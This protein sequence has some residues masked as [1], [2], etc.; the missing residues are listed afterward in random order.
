MATSE[1]D[2]Y[3]LALSA[4]G[5]R[6]S[7]SSP[8]ENSREAEI[9]NLWFP[10]VRDFILRSAPWPSAKGYR[11]LT[12]LAE[13]DFS[14]PWVSG[15]P[16]PE[17]RFAYAVPSSMLTPRYLYGFGR[18]ALSVYTSQQG[19]TR[20]LMTDQRDAIL[21]FTRRE[22]NVALWDQQLLMA[23]VNALAAVIAMPLHGK[24]D[25][26]AAAA[27]QANSYIL[28]ARVTNANTD[29]VQYESV[30]SWIAARGYGDRA[31]DAKFVYPDG[32]M[33]SMKALGHVS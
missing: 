12:V 18:F 4:V 33:F 24:P 19:S 9:C 10:R 7:V 3:N 30:P 29:Q 22:T 8:T 25:R 23:V 11:R 31:P 28:E 21:C 6:S 32:P 5:T 1:V 15:D 26:A 2:I 27:E 17:F 13:R 14:A 20:A 16:D